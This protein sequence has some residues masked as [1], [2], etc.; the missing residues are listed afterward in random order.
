MVGPAGLDHSKYRGIVDLDEDDHIQSIA[1]TPLPALALLFFP[2][3]W[4]KS[5][6][7]IS[8]RWSRKLRTHI[9]AKWR[10]SVVVLRERNAKKEIFSPLEKI[11][12]E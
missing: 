2:Q 4:V 10:V 6:R 3:K 1:V 7:P 9:L 5:S 11:P 12:C 8:T